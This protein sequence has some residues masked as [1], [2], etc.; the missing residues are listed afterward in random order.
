MI[1]RAPFFLLIG[2]LNFSLAFSQP[3]NDDFAFAV[4][5]SS[6]INSC[7]ADAVFTTS[8]ATADMNPGSCW[9]TSPANNVWFTFNGTATGNMKIT[10]DRGGSKGTIRRINAAVWEADGV[11]QVACK[12]YIG[13]DDDIIIEIVG[14]LTNGD[15]YYLSVDNNYAPYQGTFTLCLDD[16]DAGI[17]YD[18]YEGALDINS[19]VN[20]CSADAAY[21]TFGMTADKNAGSCWNTSPANNVWFTFN[22]TATGNMKITIDR[23]GS[24]GTIRRINA[25]VWEADGVTQVACKRY[26]GNDDDIII[27]IV[28]GLTN[29]DQYYLSVDNNYAPYQ[30]TFTLCLDDTDAGITYDYYEGALDI[31]S[32]VNSCSA[33]AAYTTFGMTAD[34]NAGSCWNTSP[35]NNVWFTFNGTATGNMKITIDRGGS[36]GTIRRINAAVWEA[37][38]V[39][40]VACKR[41]IGNDDDIIIEIVGGL[42]NGDQYYL[43]VDNNYAPYQGT[44]TLCL[45]DTD[46]GITYD[47]YEGALDIN[48]LV[49]SCSADAAYTTFGMTADK[50]AGSCWNTSPANNVWFTFNGTATGN[51]KI[52]I[53]RGGSKGTIRRINA[54]VWEADGVTQVACKRY[55]GND[56]DI[57]IEIVGGLTNGDQYYLSVDNNYAPYQGTFTLCLDDTDAGITYDYYEGALDINSLVN[58]CSADAAYTTFGMTADKNAGSCWNTSPANNV[59]FT[60]NGTATGN[61]KITID[62]GGSKGTIRRINAAVWEADGVTQVACKRYIGNDDD[63]I[64]EI[65]GGLTNG[66][67]Y[68]LSVDNNYAP[69]QGTFTLCLDD[70]A[71]SYDFYEGAVVLNDI[72]NWCSADAAYTTYAATADKNPGSCWNTSPANNVWF[73]FVATTSFVDID[74]KRGGSLGSIRRINVALW[75]SDGVTQISCNRYIGNDDNVS[76]GDVNLTPGNTYYISVDNNY[77]PYQGSF[78]LCVTDEPD[79]D[80]YEGA[81]ELSDLNNWCSAN[82]AY[83]T[84]GATSDKNAAS[85]WN[86]SPNFNRWFKFNAVSSNVTIQANTNGAEGTVRR[87]QLALWEADG[88]TELGCQRYA[89]NDDDLFISYGLLT[90]GND[91]Y[92]SVDNNYAPYQGSFTLCIDNID[93]VYYSRADGAWNDPNTWSLVGFG[94]VPAPSYPQIGD[95][96][97]IQDND[98]TVSSSEVTAEVN[99]TVS[100]DNSNLTISGGSLSISGN[101]S[102]TNASLGVNA[103]ISIINGSLGVGNNLIINKNGSSGAVS[104]AGS[105]SSLNVGNDLIINSTAGSTDNSINFSLS[106]SI[107]IGNDLILSNSGGPKS[108]VTLD[109]STLTIYNDLVYTAPADNLVEV[110]LVNASNFHLKNNISQGSP[111]YGILNSTGSSTVHY[112]SAVNLQTMA[113]TDGSGTG[114]AIN[115]E[116]LTIN[117]SRLTTPQV[118][119]GGNVT[120]TGTLTFIDG[121][122]F[123]SSGNLL[124]LAAGSSATGASLNSFVDGPVKKIGN[125]D[126]EFPIGDAN[127]WQPLEIG[128]LTGDAATEFTAEYYQATYA[129]VSNL[130]SPDPNGDLY[131]VSSVEFWNLLNTGTASD[132]DI[133]LHW[134]DQ[135][136]SDIDNG[137]DLQIARYTG[138]EWENLG[139]NS[140]SFADPGSISVS[141]ISTF[142]DLTFGSLSTAFNPLPVE[143]LYFI[144]SSRFN[145]IELRWV[146]ATEIENDYFL[147]EYSND[148]EN[149]EEIGKVGGNGTTTSK[150][151]YSFIDNFPMKGIQY[152][153]LGQYD[154]NGDFELLDIALIEHA[155]IKQSRIDV[156]PNPLAGSWLHLKSKSIAE[157]KSISI[158][159]SIG[160]RIP[161]D[162]KI[163]S[164]TEA[165]IEIPT[166]SDLYI[167]EISTDKGLLH[168]RIIK[169]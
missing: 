159:N 60:F 88:L 9:N 95:V 66:D 153:R 114:D 93:Q 82:A 169:L 79:Y 121:E 107:S 126:F 97:N 58:S 146:T 36:K 59:W 144:A 108:T 3:A 139:Q 143:L 90:P 117:N 48:S 147:I 132:A 25:A 124:S 40:Q 51:M 18:Y 105:T 16:T 134:K 41:Y 161:R 61:M 21:T 13:N 49:N 140:I 64:I 103:A 38:G 74:V 131:N 123:S 127:F 7:S 166:S 77:A 149:W 84:Y 45:D 118:S 85:C 138:A 160:K 71:V 43:S 142:G 110:A 106:S 165:V 167:I 122:V 6:L 5:I 28:G 47:Y 68:Y 55:I 116:N 63:I 86:T 15:Q 109:G 22:G 120:L 42:T 125:T 20:S 19:L 10:I 26:I 78:T 164:P 104:L 44:F 53:D 163:I 89:G 31:N 133:T 1:S 119:L 137:P 56:D 52:T 150:N 141:G 24:K 83:T 11:T 12:R 76:V 111:A 65:V 156:W 4:G 30:G 35:A 50:N 154:F 112:S 145:S 157:I 113:S 162:L 33:D 115:Y 158:I 32:L 102:L 57:I 148:G 14:G 129:D 34:K 151:E 2:I 136:R 130:K 91:Y 152:Y 94:G 27:E 128:N 29:G 168:K 23:G 80:F 17:T 54:A 70:N 67:Q 155:G 96:A 92:I 99:L 37:D 8:A 72:N 101:S 73:S 62:R 87:L 46:A 69:Y 75:E 100:S 98:I 135:S 81:T 39:T